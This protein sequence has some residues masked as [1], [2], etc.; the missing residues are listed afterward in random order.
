MKK[1]FAILVVLILVTVGLLVVGYYFTEYSNQ[2]TLT[3][4]F[5]S[6]TTSSGTKEFKS[7]DLLDFTVDIPNGNLVTEKQSVVVISSSFGDITVYR[8]STEFDNL[9]DYLKFVEEMNKLGV[10]A[11]KSLVINGFDAQSSLIGLNNSEDR[12]KNYSIYVDSQIYVLSTSSEALYDD[13]DQIAQ[14]FRYTPN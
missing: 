12:E 14:S 1:G 6:N 4:T 2:Q 7:S 3:G 8:N 5:P 9:G 13:L 10:T 11:R